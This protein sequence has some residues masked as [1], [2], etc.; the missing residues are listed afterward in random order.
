M[1]FAAY[2][3]ENVIWGTGETE[4]A[5]MLDARHWL[6]LNHEDGS[7]AMDT[8]TVD[9]CTVGVVDA[10]KSRGGQIAWQWSGTIHRYMTLR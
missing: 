1:K 3:S 5:A 8:L 9:P 7:E 2:D 4:E 6:A 10:V